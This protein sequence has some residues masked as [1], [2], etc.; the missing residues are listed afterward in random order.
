MTAAL[1]MFR[2]QE[3]P[4]PWSAR[5][6]SA[7]PIPF[8]IY[9]A[10][11]SLGSFAIKLAK[12]SNIHPIIAIAGGSRDYVSKLIDPSKGDKIVDY[13]QGTEKMKEDVKAALGPLEAFH[14]FDCISEHG[15]WIPLSQMVTP[16]GGQVSVVSGA[17]AYTE[18]EIPTGVKIKYV[19]VGT[20]HDGAYI[21]TMPKQPADKETVE[22]AIEF[23][24]VF[25]RYLARMLQKGKF[26]GHPFEVIAGGLD[27]VE[28]GLRRL[29]KGESRGYKFVY[30]IEET[31]A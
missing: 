1:A 20:A 18:V 27:G 11:S 25:Y 3:L 12:A 31:K 21:A 13:R 19:Y 29:K 14:A 8:I 4:P 23:A 26:E 2:C 17:N 5:T 6:S 24:Y 9:G 30:R 7:G 10:S 15:S 28:E 16:S 22:T